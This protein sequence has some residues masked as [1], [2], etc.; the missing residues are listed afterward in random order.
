MIE[1][2]KSNTEDY[3]DLL[4]ERNDREFSAFKKLNPAEQAKHQAQ[5]FLHYAK[6]PW[7]FLRDCVHTLN[8]V[9]KDDYAIQPFPSYLE[10]LK[11]LCEL[12]QREDK[13]AI[14]K[15]RRMVC[16]WSFI[17]LY[18]HDTLFKEGRFNAFVSKKEQDAGELVARAEFIYHKIPDWRIPKALLPKIKG[19]KMT[20]EPWVLEFEKTHSQIMAFP[21]GAHQMRQY[22]I[23]GI[24][25]DETAFWEQAQAFYSASKPTLDGGGRMTLI[26][27]R[28]PGFFKKI[29]FD[30]LDAQD[31]N[32][33]EKPPVS[34]KSPLEGVQVWKNPKNKF[35][36]VDLHYTADPRKR[37]M[38]W[39]EEQKA[40]MPKRDFNMEYEKSWTTFEEKPVF[41]DFSRNIHVKENLSI[42]PQ[43]PLLLA[44]TFGLTPSCLI[45]QL[46]GRTLRFHKEFQ[47]EGSIHKLS[48]L[49][50]SHL[51]LDYSSWLARDMIHVWAHPEGFEKNDTDEKSCVQVLRG[52]GLGRV[53]GGEPVWETG[54]LAVE[55]YMTRIYGD[56]PALQIS[57][58]CP[59]LIES[60]S[61][62]YRYKQSAGEESAMPIQ[63]NFARMAECAQFICSAVSQ[64]RKMKNVN[65]QTPHYG[66]QN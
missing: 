3:L 36:V 6:T 31:L 21:Q 16:S 9:S 60:L 43:I 17:S 38:K 18:T 32:F 64:T 14:P 57:E 8:Q 56:G 4:L 15:S 66:F 5:M 58:D 34:P 50:A 29:V 54:K 46:V 39:R 33:K 27:S 1:H 51:S 35:V 49:V 63:D 45:A 41:T 7:A 26:S 11:F 13:L 20:K 47:V 59:I 30:Q 25:G 24:L 19:G 48:D 61:G 12:W 23:S 52:A 2:P 65:I 42:E 22:T 28:S 37:G 44:F 53:R 40:S 10:Y 62:G 55:T